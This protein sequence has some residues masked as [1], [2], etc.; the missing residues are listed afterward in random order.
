MKLA[1]V[2]FKK[3]LTW[4]QQLGPEQLCHFTE[5][6]GSGH[7]HLSALK[8]LISEG[9]V[10]QPWPVSLC[11]QLYF[12]PSPALLYIER[13]HPAGGRFLGSQVS[14][15]V[16][17][18]GYRE[19]WARDRSVG[20]KEKQEATPHSLEWLCLLCDSNYLRACDP[21]PRHLSSHLP[22]LSLTAFLLWPISVLPPFLL[23]MSLV[24]NI[25]S[26]SFSWLD[27]DW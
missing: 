15:L 18:F 6:F 21:G 1:T 9:S 23:Y 3:D 8:F 16:T 25:R 13:V 5:R 2:T 11:P 4:N 14:W 26:C 7:L 12:W 22:P 10:C 17:G 24:I 20:G 19:V 27:P